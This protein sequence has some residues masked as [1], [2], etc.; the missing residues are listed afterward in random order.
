MV[1]GTFVIDPMRGYPPGTAAGTPTT[2]SWHHQVHD[3][4]GPVVFLIAVPAACVVI[5]LRLKSAWRVYSFVTAAAA[6]G[7]VPGSPLRGN[8]M[9]PTRD[10]SS[11][12]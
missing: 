1:A 5:G 6:I 3:V 9:R 8:A 7:L 11:A 10:S 12:R 2:F 4:V